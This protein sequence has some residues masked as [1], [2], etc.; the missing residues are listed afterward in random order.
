MSK[1]FT[2]S[3][4]SVTI[5]MNKFITKVSERAPPISEAFI[6]GLPSNSIAV[7]IKKNHY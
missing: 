7:L 5:L 3:L 1:T 6:E 2:K 4:P